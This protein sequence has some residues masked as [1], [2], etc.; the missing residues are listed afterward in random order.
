M[1]IN[2]ISSWTNRIFNNTLTENNVRRDSY[3]PFKKSNFQKNILMEDVFQSSKNHSS[4][5]L[6][7]S[8]KLNAGSKRIYSTFVGSITNF[9]NKIQEGIEAI[10]AFGTR[11]KNNIVN[12]W[13]KINEIGSREI[14]LDGVKSV[15]NYDMANLF[16]KSHEREIAK[17]AKLDPH[18]EVKPMLTEALSALEADLAIAA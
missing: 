2:K 18:T 16:G 10:N 9:G 7:F 3:N 6:N 11:M 14:K 8:G 17:M 13:H 5:K 4:E 1:P 12:T 15:L